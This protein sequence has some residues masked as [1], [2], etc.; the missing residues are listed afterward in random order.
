MCPPLLPTTFKDRHK[1]TLV[2]GVNWRVNASQ[3][4]SKSKLASPHK[5][6]SGSSHT[7]LIQDLMS[8]RIVV[9]LYYYFRLR[10]YTFKR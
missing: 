2:P 5:R 10:S 1:Y 9:Y 6:Q 8:A 4:H 3:R 7:A